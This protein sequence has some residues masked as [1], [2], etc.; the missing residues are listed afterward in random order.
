MRKQRRSSRRHSHSPGCDQRG[1]RRG[2]H[3]PAF[4]GPAPAD[5]DRDLYSAARPLDDAQS[6]RRGLPSVGSIRGR[7]VQNALSAA[8]VRAAA[9]TPALAEVVRKEQDLH[10]QALAQAG[11]LNNLLAEPPRRAMQMPSR[12]FSRS[13]PSCARRG[14]KRA[15]TFSGAS[16]STPASPSRRLQPS[17]TFA[18]RCGPRKRCSRSIS[19]PA[20]ASCGRYPSRGRSPLPM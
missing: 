5:R 8:A 15:A 16:P 11:A 7:S 20:R 9:R 13:W 2:R 12:S 4:D 14:W 18:R 3:R 17:T 1:G 6:C 10:K 19:G